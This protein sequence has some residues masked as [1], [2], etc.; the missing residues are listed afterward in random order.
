MK[1]K[2]VLLVI[3]SFVLLF[4]SCKKKEDKIEIYLTKEPIE[5]TEGIHVREFFTD[6]FIKEKN[7]SSISNINRLIRKNVRIDTIK[8]EFIYC[9]DF[10][11]TKEQLE[12]NPFIENSEIIEFN[13]TNSAFK[14][15]ETVKNKFEKIKSYD[16]KIGVQFVVCVN[17]KPVMFGYF[18]KGFMS[19]Y[20]S[21]N[22]LIQIGHKEQYN[23][24]GNIRSY[25][26]FGR[27]FQLLD[28]IKEKEFIKALK[29]TNR[30]VQD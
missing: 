16:D 28:T 19:S 8:K 2:K 26:G 5:F 4:S 17:E 21:E 30:L 9:G 24:K 3:F 10:K 7:E 11:A 12:K 23:K 6:D 20:Y 25:I 27:R 15:S 22:Y 13:K 1:S 18:I 29:N 14:F